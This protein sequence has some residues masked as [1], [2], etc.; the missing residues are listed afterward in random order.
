MTFKGPATVTLEAVIRLNVEAPVAVIVATDINDTVPVVAVRLVNPPLP[1]VIPLFV[2]KFASLSNHACSW[3]TLP[4]FPNTPESYIWIILLALPAN[5]FNANAAVLTLT[6]CSTCV[7]VEFATNAVPATC[8]RDKFASA[9]LPPPAW[10]APCAL[11]IV[12]IVPSIFD[13]SILSL[14]TGCRQSLKYVFPG[15]VDTKIFAASTPTATFVFVTAPSAKA[16]VSTPPTSTFRATKLY[17]LTP[18][19]SFGLSASPSTEIFNCGFTPRQSNPGSSVASHT[20][21]NSPVAGNVTL[22]TSDSN[23]T[24]VDGCT[25]ASRIDFDPL[26]ATPDLNSRPWYVM[27]FGTAADKAPPSNNVNNKVDFF[28]GNPPLIHFLF[29]PSKG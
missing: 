16:A 9:S 27:R 11:G 6:A 1:A 24:K 7:N 18:N 21:V 17:G 2:T 28:M 15:L 3:G 19:N 26:T 4:V 22:N 8:V 13:A 23:S 14:L 12:G 5:P 20:I 29:Q 25:S 10:L